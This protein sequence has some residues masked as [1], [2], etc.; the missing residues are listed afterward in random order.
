MDNCYEVATRNPR[1]ESYKNVWEI[2]G[3]KLQDRNLLIIDD[4]WG[5]LKE[6]WQSIT[7]TLCKMQ[8]GNPMQRK[9]HLVLNFT[10]VHLLI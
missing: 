9:I 10:L 8:W 3:E 1:Y 7:S 5:P 2:I 6:E 4:L